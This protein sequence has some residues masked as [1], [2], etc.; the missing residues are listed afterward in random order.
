MGVTDCHVHINPVWEMHPDAVRILTYTDETHGRY[1]REPRAFLEY[2]DAA[3]VERALLINYVAPEVIGYTEKANEFVS[4]Y[5]EADPDRLIAV[6]GIR[7][8]HPHPAEEVARL[9]ERRGIRAIKLHPPH[10]LFRPE[11][12]CRRKFPAAPRTVPRRAPATV[13]Q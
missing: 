11:R 3:Q 8:D 7:P 1:L 13:C 5:C 2:L 10:Q 12:L 6:G 9:A 4:R